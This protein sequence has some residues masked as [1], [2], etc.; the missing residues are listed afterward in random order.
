MSPAEDLSTP[1]S[2][3]RL[4]LVI[5]LGVDFDCAYIP[6]L[7]RHYGGTVDSWN[8][9][10]QSND[11]SE[12]GLATIEEAAQ[13]I[14]L[15]LSAIDSAAQVHTQSWQGEFTSRRKVDRLNALVEDRVPRGEWVLYI[16]ADEFVE[17]PGVLRPLVAEC[18]AA[19]N[20]VVFG[21]MVDRFTHDRQPY[22][23]RED[24]DLFAA[25]PHSESYT[26]SILK[27]WDHKSC[28]MKYKEA[29]L[30]ANC[31]EYHGHT[32]ERYQ[33]AGQVLLTIWH[34]KWV[35]S[36]RGKLQRRVESFRKLGIG[37][38]RESAIGLRDI[39][40]EK[41]DSRSWKPCR[42]G[43]IRGR[44]G[45]QVL[46][47]LDAATGVQLN[48]TAA[49]I[50][51]ICD[52]SRTETE[53]LAEL[54]ERFKASAGSLQK[55]LR[56]ALDELVTVGAIAPRGGETM[57][58]DD[59]RQPGPVPRPGELSGGNGPIR[60]RLGLVAETTE[61]FLNQVRLCLFSLRRNGGALKDIPV[62]LITNC[63][64]LDVAHQ[65]F[66]TRHFA[67]IEFR[68]APRLGAIPHTSK[69]NVFWAID[70]S[71]Y[72]VL[73][74]LD[75]DTVVRRALDRI[76]DPILEGSAE[77]LCRRGGETDRGMFVDFNGLVNQYCGPKRARIQYRGQEEW[78]MFNS[79]VFLATSE[80]V[81]KIRRGAIEFTYRI[82][83]DWQRADALQKLPEEIR[84]LV[85]PNPPVRQN[86]TIEQGALALSCIN[87]GVSVQYLDETYNS[88]GGEE[89]FHVLHCFK[90][91]YQFDRR[92]MFSASAEQWIKEYSTSDIPGKAFLAS[93]M[94][95]YTQAFL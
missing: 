11:E 85:N 91:L 81:H 70:P 20:P 74:Y 32:W 39:Y 4:H 49:L 51:E 19:G 6:H 56:K 44:T 35:E 10:L 8:V 7:C 78:P 50:W 31:H 33:E 68:T 43:V 41:P 16:D 61:G 30:L 25:M 89:D 34:F 71:S 57:A 94:R 3:P 2:S 86:W 38:W 83:N 42:R 84:N 37:W 18:E 26:K 28:L 92:S 80:A 24:V 59:A 87:A 17:A 46:V 22:S 29:P 63:D 75:C 66:F 21:C 60:V 93:M 5:C 95:R 52:G 12:K 82:F 65:A 79:G 40:G 77:F 69:L 14:R 45:G 15:K 72:D 53:L 1:G 13:A 62:T 54:S 27:G 47:E 67:P 9:L 76:A 55:D 73:L 64:S 58:T 48:A 23:L 90:S 88:W 36:S